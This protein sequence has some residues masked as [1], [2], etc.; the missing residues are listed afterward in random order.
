[1][2]ED[3]AVRHSWHHLEKIKAAL[4]TAHPGIRRTT[5]TTVS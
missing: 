2:I 1:M 3:H 5:L 4:R